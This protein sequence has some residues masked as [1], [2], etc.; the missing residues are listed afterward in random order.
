MAVCDRPGGGGF[1]GRVLSAP[2]IRPEHDSGTHRAESRFQ[3]RRVE[4]RGRYVPE[5]LRSGVGRV[6]RTA[7]LAAS[8]AHSRAASR[9]IDLGSSESDGAGILSLYESGTRQGQPQSIEWIFW[10]LVC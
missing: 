3:V 8:S 4:G 7:V 10:I 1:A 5:L 9:L 2:R 6:R